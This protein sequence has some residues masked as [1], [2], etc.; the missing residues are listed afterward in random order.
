MPA[1]AIGSVQKGIYTALNGNVTLNSSAVPV[2]TNAVEGKSYPFILIPNVTELPMNLHAD[3]GSNT[4]AQVEIWTQ[5]SNFYRHAD[6]NS[7]IS[8]IRSLLDHVTLT[9]P[10]GAFL[11]CIL[12]NNTKIEDPD[13]RTLRGVCRYTVMVETL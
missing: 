13:G 2:C 9:V 1:S 8:Q 3:Y 4:T 12:D 6:V 11:A 5:G 7:A 10:T